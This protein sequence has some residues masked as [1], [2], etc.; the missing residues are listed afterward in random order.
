MLLMRIQHGFIV[1]LR[2]AFRTEIVHPSGLV[3]LAHIL[4][5]LISFPL[6]TY[7]YITKSIKEHNDGTVSCYDLNDT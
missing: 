7:L 6:S 2:G 1:R 4:Q 5:Q 3:V